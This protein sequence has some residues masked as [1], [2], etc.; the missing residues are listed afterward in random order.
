MKYPYKRLVVKVGSNVITGTDGL[1]D[2]ARIEHL[3]EEIVQ[4]K[5]S[6]TEVV[7]VS[8]GAVAS[9]RSL[10][11]TQHIK[12]TVS[13][14]QLL[15]SVGQVKLLETYSRLLNKHG[16]TCAQVLVTKEDF[17]DR[18][19]YLNMKNCFQVLLMNEVLPIVNENDVVSVTELMFTDNDEL[20]GLVCSMLNADALII[21]SNVDGIF[22]NHPSDPQAK[23][24][25]RIKP[26]SSDFAQFI[27]PV[28]SQFGRGGMIT[29]TNMAQKI[30]RLGIPVHI[31]RGTRQHVLTDLLA[32]QLPHTVFEAAK[33]TSGTKKWIAHSAPSA[34]GTVQINEGAREALRSGKAIS[35]LPIGIQSIL[36]P[37]NKG[38][39][40]RI[41]DEQK[42]LV[43]LG[44][45]QYG[46]EKAA[47]RIGKKKE[48]ELIHYDYLYLS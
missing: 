19:H 13:A 14:R 26:G 5:Q 42:K 29:K 39:V 16:V 32:G 27:T 36:A 7:L 20:A 38:D 43:G 28:K 48:K 47:E 35:L 24:I 11:S 6:G 18:Q 41:V 23:L 25:E 10:I 12:D 46:S 8:S 17:R 2:Q 30:A 44:I 1:I 33:E 31:A 45:A 21:L 15:A 9:G 40:I 22:T 34:T 4:L 3:V 37:F